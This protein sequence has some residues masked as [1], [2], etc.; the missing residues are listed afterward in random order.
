[1]KRTDVETLKAAQASV[2]IAVFI[3]DEWDAFAADTVRRT[4]VTATLKPL[5]QG[6][7]GKSSEWSHGV[8]TTIRPRPR[9]VSPSWKT[10]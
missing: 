3:I 5:Y 10:A 2:E 1:L 7:T 4:A 8:R 9:W 6:L